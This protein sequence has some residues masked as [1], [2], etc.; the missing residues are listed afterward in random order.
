MSTHKKITRRDYVY[1]T[2]NTYANNDNDGNSSSR[3]NNKQ[4][5]NKY[6]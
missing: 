4:L 6:I 2:V 5:K 1:W 3:T